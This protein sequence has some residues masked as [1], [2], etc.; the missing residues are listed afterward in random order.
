M[1]TI[2]I[3]CGAHKGAGK[4]RVAQALARLLPDA[5]CAKLGCAPA[6]LEKPAHYFR[7]P[8]AFR[9]FIHRNRHRTHLVLEVNRYA[10][11]RLGD[12]VV[13]VE[14][15][16]GHASPRPDV[17]RLRA[18]AHNRIPDARRNWEKALARHLPSASMRRKA[19][20]VFA[21]QTRFRRDD[22]PAVRT[23]VWFVQRGKRIF[24]P[25]LA[26]LLETLE[27]QG[28]L[29]AAADACAVSYRHAWG[30][31]RAAERQ[32]GQPLVRRQPGGT[33]GGRTT[34]TT[35]G[36]RWRVVFRKVNREVELCA[37]RAFA[38]HWKK[39]PSG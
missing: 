27:E 19:C 39:E 13:F 35:E 8:R 3:V 20:A 18:A 7:D 38:R 15:A 25:G 37:D 21:A 26:R 6:K 5:L 23:K 14:G 17:A 12:V 36:Q 4:T 10:D 32:F 1:A 16:P 2:W 29:R 11:R 9:A 33:G 22:R 30:L 31:L 24:G 28:T 34:L